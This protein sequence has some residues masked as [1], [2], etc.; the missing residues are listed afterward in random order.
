MYFG[1]T[2]AWIEAPRTLKGMHNYP[3]DT[4]YSLCNF[5]RIDGT[6]Q[7]NSAHHVSIIRLKQFSK[8]SRGTIWSTLLAFYR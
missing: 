7:S 5:H 8:K 1:D 6:E 4:L 2:W 3:T